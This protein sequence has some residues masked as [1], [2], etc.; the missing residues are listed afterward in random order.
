MVRTQVI[1]P[2]EIQ[3]HHPHLTLKQI[4]GT[5]AHFLPIT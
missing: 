3:E 4:Y 2:V 5:I 1:I